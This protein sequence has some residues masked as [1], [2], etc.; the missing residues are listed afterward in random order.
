MLPDNALLEIFDFYKG[1]I[2][3]HINFKWGWETLTQVCRRWRHVVFGSPRRLNLR[4]VCTN[5][6]RARRL[7]DIWPTFPVIV[8]FPPLSPA[9]DSKGI[10]NIIAALEHRDRISEIHIFNIDGSVLEKL[11][12]VMH[13]PL[14]ILIHLTLRSS[15]EYDE[16]AR[17]LP[18]TFLGGS[19]PHLQS[20]LLSGVS[21]KSFPKFVLCFTHIA[22]LHLGDIPNSGCISPGVMAT[23]LTTCPNLKSLSIG[24][25]SP[26]SRPLQVGLP[27]LKRAVLPALTRL[28][29]CG[30]SE[31]FE[32]FVSR[33]DTPLLNQLIVSFF[34]DLVFEIPRLH[35]FIDRTARLGPFSQAAIEF[36]V[37]AA[38][39]VFFGPSTRFELEIR[40][41]R[42]DWQL[43]S[44]TQI[45]SHQLPFLS[46][47][48]QLEICELP[49]GISEWEDDPDVNSSQWLELFYLFVAVQNLHVS[50]GLVPPVANA[51][52]QLTGQTAIEVL[53]ALCDLFL[54][55]FQPYG[56]VHDVIESF[57]TARQL[58][59]QPVVIQRWEPNGPTL[60]RS[61]I[62]SQLRG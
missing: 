18:E 41:E 56:P 47:V 57:V 5:T 54:E 61:D 27:P 40:C 11:V 58:S 22:Y 26:L 24:F 12:T 21:V 1:D 9:M 34:M 36:S 20:F 50:K 31:Y 25:R 53:P 43:W 33:I 19:A 6:T 52:Q 13:E 15:D 51:L 37:R 29:F 2:T 46:Y 10:E 35:N 23:C 16:S 48:E 17:E 59:G 60:P 62:Q 4:V 38:K 42:R 7:R 45:F 39:I 8:F 44:M 55:G 32:D 49:W 3:N 30:V 28:S 14:P